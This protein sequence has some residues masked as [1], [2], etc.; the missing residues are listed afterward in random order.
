MV[1]LKG[2]KKTFIDG[3][4]KE[5]A[6]RGRYNLSDENAFH[7][8]QNRSRCSWIAKSITEHDVTGVKKAE[9]AVTIS[10]Q[11]D[12]S[13]DSN[14]EDIDFI[15][16]YQDTSVTE[17]TGSKGAPEKPQQAASIN[18]ETKPKSNRW[19][20]LSQAVKAQAAMGGLRLR[21]LSSD[22]DKDI[23]DHIAVQLRKNYLF[24]SL[25]DNEIFDLTMQ[26]EVAKYYVG[27]VIIEQGEV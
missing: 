8:V 6:H 19:R 23:I 12:R 7:S 4:E 20:R 1:S 27:D 3:E 13:D 9:A 2:A 10:P 11:E 17:I 18:G 21:K 14:A 25:D 24:T 26:F 22:S 15:K 16:Q 5:E